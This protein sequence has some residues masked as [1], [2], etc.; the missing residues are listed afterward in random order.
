VNNLAPVA[1]QIINNDPKT[2]VK[3]ITA[4]TIRGRS[5]SLFFLI[6]NAFMPSILGNR[7]IK[8]RR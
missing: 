6:L 2:N 7:W 8:R 1:T 3:H 5:I 4:R